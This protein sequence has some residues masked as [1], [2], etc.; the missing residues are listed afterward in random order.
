MCGIFG[1]AAPAGNSA[2]WPEA[3]VCLPALQCRGPDDSGWRTSDRVVFGHRRLSIIDISPAGRQPLTN[4]NQT[5]W[6]VFNGEIYGFDQLRAKLEA[7]GHVFSSNSDTEVIVHGYEEWGRDVLKRMNGMF[8]L[9]IWDAPRNRLLLARDRLGKKPLYWCQRA[10]RVGFASLIRP[11]MLSGLVDAAISPQ[12]L[13]EYLYFNY[14]LGPDSIFHDVKQIPPAGWLEFDEDGLRMGSYWDLADTDTQAAEK[15]GATFPELLADSIRTRLV[16][17]VPLGVFLSGGIDSA[18]VAALATR[19][20]GHAIP[21]FTVGFEEA[22]YD[23]RPKARKVA[24]RL[25]IEACETVCRPEDVIE[26]LPR[27]AASADNLLADQS[28][29]PLAKLASL[30]SQQV[31][32]ILTGDGGDELLGGYQTYSALRVAAPY[33]RLTPPGIREFVARMIR[34]VPKAS[35]KMEPLA[36]LQRFLDATTGDVAKAH[37]SWRN[38][39]RSR[40]IDAL[41]PS[42]P[43]E[44]PEWEAYAQHMR[45]NPDWSQDRRAVYADIRTWLVD[46]ILAKVDRSTMAF[47]LEARSPLLDFH[48]MEHCFGELLLTRNG[49]DK[50]A[51]REL[52][53]DLLG[54]DIAH[55]QKAGFQTPFA[56][57]LRGPLNTYVE[58]C[59]VVLN[60]R[61]GD[62][63]DATVIRTVVSEHQFGRYNH[64]YKIWGLLALA[65]WLRLY[66]EAY[67]RFS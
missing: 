61:L 10:G 4:E 51:I 14:T 19:E 32:V 63:I 57:W 52:G 58:E 3:E 56:Q 16:S 36:I 17:D 50:H 9:A 54:S 46:S 65:E 5:V 62:T 64:D 28:M 48:L 43:S 26:L 20:L 55:T 37:A 13:R 39:W 49:F 23:E 67:V 35:R 7:A 53:S 34:R 11:L 29:V 40:E 12:K 2:P 66:P 42:V 8:A 30:A 31:K 24:R 41:L 47:G 25:G 60:E 21:V 1:I 22:T 59:V 15:Q 38:I 44:R 33:I 18:L 45:G 6:V 27:L